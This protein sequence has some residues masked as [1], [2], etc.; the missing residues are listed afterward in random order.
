M[1]HDELAY[2]VDR[3]NDLVDAIIRGQELMHD[4]QKELD[5]RECNPFEADRIFAKQFGSLPVSPII[6]V[7]NGISYETRVLHQ[8]GIGL[9][10][11]RNADFLYEIRDLKYIL[12][13]FKQREG[14]KPVAV[15][16]DQLQNLIDNCSVACKQI[17]PNVVIN[18]GITVNAMCGSWYGI[19]DGTRGE[20][21]FPACEAKRILKSRQRKPDKFSIGLTDI[22]FEDMFI[23]CQS[24]GRLGL[25]A[26]WEYARTLVAQNDLVF[27]ISQSKAMGLTNPHAEN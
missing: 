24:G 12:V 8:A 17:Q 13:Q 18:P 7:R 6:R 19:F 11:I 16:Y 5:L 2:A 23:S 9:R 1:N 3:I 15:D 25:D 26:I 27:A 10:D 20:R 21:Y 14:A 4:V 22:E